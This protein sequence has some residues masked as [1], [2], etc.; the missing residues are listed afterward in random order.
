MN[1]ADEGQTRPGGG[2]FRG[3]EVEKSGT[4]TSCG[5]EKRHEAGVPWAGTPASAL[6]TGQDESWYADGLVAAWAG[7]RT[8]EAGVGHRPLHRG[9]HEHRRVVDS[10]AAARTVATSVNL[11]AV[12]LVVGDPVNVVESAVVV[13]QS[14]VV[15]VPELLKARLFGRHALVAVGK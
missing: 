8:A 15:I 5:P 13:L 2:E 3:G 14:V 1:G 7:R 4:C 12:V 11:V 6:G 9:A 10:L